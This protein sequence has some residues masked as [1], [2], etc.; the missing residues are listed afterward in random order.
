MRE[1]CSINASDTGIS[2]QEMPLRTYF[3]ETEEIFILLNQELTPDW[4]TRN[5]SSTGVL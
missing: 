3:V 4:M 5:I 2:A 1:Y